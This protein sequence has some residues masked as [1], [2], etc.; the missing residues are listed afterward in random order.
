MGLLYAA[1][2]IRLNTLLPAMIFHYLV[3]FFMGS[4]GKYFLTYVTRTG[5]TLLWTINL[6]VVVPLLIFLV[7]RYA[8]RWITS[9]TDTIP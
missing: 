4:A 2:V 9:G 5:A 6:V 3:N 7:R 1:I 8:A